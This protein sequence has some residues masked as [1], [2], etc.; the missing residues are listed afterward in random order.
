MGLRRGGEIFRGSIIRSLLELY[1]HIIIRAM[2][3]M[4]VVHI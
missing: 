1:F 4:D 3:M 2:E